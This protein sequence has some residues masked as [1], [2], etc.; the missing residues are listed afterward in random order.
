MFTNRSTLKWLRCKVSPQKKWKKKKKTT[1]RHYTLSI[2]V[3]KFAAFFL[4]KLTISS[5]ANVI[6]KFI[7]N[8]F[9]I[10]PVLNRFKRFKAYS[11]CDR[12][13]LLWIKHFVL[14][15]GFALLVI[16]F[17]QKKYALLGKWTRK[18]IYFFSPNLKCDLNQSIVYPNCAKT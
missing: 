1:K 15:L 9:P 4:Q 17:I 6:L 5:N 2:R 13:V 14:Y 11:W 3:F 10:A 8:W 12:H 7:G 16:H 18:G